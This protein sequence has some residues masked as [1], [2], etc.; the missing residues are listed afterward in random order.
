MIKI[1]FSFFILEDAKLDDKDLRIIFSK[2]LDWNQ[3]ACMRLDGEQT[4]QA[5]ILR[6]VRQGCILSPLIFNMYSE[7][8][9]NDAL[10]GVEEGILLNGVRVNNIRYA[11]D[12][13]TMVMADSLERL[14]V[15]GLNHTL[16]STTWT[17]DQRPKN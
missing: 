9:F 12:T 10:D 13:D 3:T 6:G 5:K 4:D 11:D 2:N 16:Q 7:R 15:N 1:T 8:I 17:E 14:D